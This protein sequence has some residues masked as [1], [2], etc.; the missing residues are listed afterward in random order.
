MH[1][2][3][4]TVVGWLHMSPPCSAGLQLVSSVDPTL[5]RLTMVDDEI[6]T[7][8]REK[9]PDMKVDVVNENE[10]KSASSKEVHIIYN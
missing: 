2:F 4:S 1:A 5:L 8:F 10:M 6:Y 9:F 3:G 7:K